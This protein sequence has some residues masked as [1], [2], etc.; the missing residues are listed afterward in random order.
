MGFGIGLVPESDI[1][2]NFSGLTYKEL[3]DG[4]RT[5][6]HQLFGGLAKGQ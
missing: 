3:R 2:A 6:P 5:K 1:A 4:G